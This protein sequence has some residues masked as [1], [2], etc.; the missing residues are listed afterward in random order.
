MYV[1]N[2]SGQKSGLQSALNTP[3]AKFSH[4]LDQILT[5]TCRDVFEKCIKCFSGNLHDTSS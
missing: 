1:K 3:F 5:Q 2:L 4:I